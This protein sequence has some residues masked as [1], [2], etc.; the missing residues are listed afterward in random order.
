MALLHAIGRSIWMLILLLL[1][2]WLPRFSILF[3]FVYVL[4]VPP[5][6]SPDE[7]NH[8]FRAWQISEGHI[9][10]EKQEMGDNDNESGPVEENEPESAV[11]ED[12][13]A[14]SSDNNDQAEP[15]MEAEVEDTSADEDV[16]A[17]E[18]EEV[19]ASEDN[20]TDPSTDEKEGENAPEDVTESLDSEA[21]AEESA[22]MDEGPVPEEDKS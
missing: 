4:L 7:P 14:G 3:A 8:F 15:S 18:E 9:F 19:D 1:M 12:D 22:S 6:Q 10:P 21:N 2:R 5:F 13:V 20:A 17:P 16:D 11:D